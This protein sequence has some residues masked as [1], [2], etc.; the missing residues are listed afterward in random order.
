MIWGF[1]K[2]V[3]D[4]EVFTQRE[5]LKLLF[6]FCFITHWMVYLLSLLYSNLQFLSYL[7]QQ[8]GSCGYRSSVY[9]VVA[10]EKRQLQLTT[11]AK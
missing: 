3:T 4:E 9:E 7:Q 1:E 2:F 8:S 11:E 6:I 5:I 10:F